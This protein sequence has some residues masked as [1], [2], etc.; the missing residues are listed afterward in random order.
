MVDTLNHV[1]DTVCAYIANDTLRVSIDEVP[2]GKVNVLDTIYKL[3]MIAIGVCNLIFTFFL[4]YH[5]NKSTKKKTDADHKKAILYDLVLN[6]KMDS[7]YNSFASLV[8]ESHILIEKD[9][10]GMDDKKIALDD[11]YQDWVSS[12]RLNFAEVLGA[13]DNELYYKMMYYADNLQG[14]LS[15]NLFDEGV[16]LDNKS[17]YEELIVT[18]I[19][20]TQKN[21][22]AVINS[23]I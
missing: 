21:M 22:L 19:L 4:F 11:K 16:N 20:N 3:A 15:E 6:Y 12:F 23:Y 18:P 9:G 1:V 8:K 17:K 5:N 13:I 2:Q 7:F 10:T 14:V